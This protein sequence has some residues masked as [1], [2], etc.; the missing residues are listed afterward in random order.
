MGLQE[1][2][3]FAKHVLHLQYRQRIEQLAS[4]ALREHTHLE[5][6]HAFLVS[7]ATM[8]QAQW[9][10]HALNAALAPTQHHP[11]T[12]RRVQYVHQ[13][14]CPLMQVSTV[15]SARAE[16]IRSPIAHYVPHV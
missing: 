15:S 7:Q 5:A 10:I 3:A 8:H 14:V 11:Q 13:E 1:E 6:Q 2:R 16:H 4:P 12:Q 9:T